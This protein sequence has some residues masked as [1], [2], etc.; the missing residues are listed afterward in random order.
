MLLDAFLAMSVSLLGEFPENY[1][2]IHGGFTYFRN[3]L[4]RKLLTTNF[5]I[6]KML[7]NVHLLD[8]Y[9]KT[10]MFLFYYYLIPAK[11]TKHF[12]TNLLFPL[13]RFMINIS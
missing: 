10:I 1:M 5:S 11:M 7:K 3:Y 8:L 2:Y 4:Q 13:L 6:L 12:G 9:I